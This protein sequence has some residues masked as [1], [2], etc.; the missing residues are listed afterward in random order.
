LEVG[1]DKSTNEIVRRGK[2]TESGTVKT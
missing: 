1:E 2:E